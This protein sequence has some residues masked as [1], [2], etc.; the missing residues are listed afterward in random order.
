[1]HRHHHHLLLCHYQHLMHQYHLQSL[2]YLF[3]IRLCLFQLRGDL[4]HHHR[5]HQFGLVEN[6]KNLL[7]LRQ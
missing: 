7:D 2:D 4:H 6:Q 5:C 3:L 1:M